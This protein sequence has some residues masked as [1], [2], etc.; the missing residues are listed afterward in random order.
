ME[1]EIKKTAISLLSPSY[2]LSNWERHKITVK[3][4]TSYFNKA[5]VDPVMYLKKKQVLK[6]KSENQEKIRQREMEGLSVDDLLKKEK[7]LFEIQSEINRFTNTVV[8][9]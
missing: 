4:E 7:A 3:T 9:R 6:M 8:Q 5:V 2:E 1:K